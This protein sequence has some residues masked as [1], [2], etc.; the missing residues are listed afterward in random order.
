MIQFSFNEPLFHYTITIIIGSVT[1]LQTQHVLDLELTSELQKAMFIDKEK[2]A[3]IY[4]EGCFYKNVVIYVGCD[5]ISLLNRSIFSGVF[6]ELNQEGV[7]YSE[8]NNKLYAAMIEFYTSNIIKG[9]DQEIEQD[10]TFSIS[11][12]DISITLRKE[13]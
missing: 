3:F 5:D 12:N 13:N 2:G 9:V 10:H 1:E 8:T 6:L 11:A 4:N 7:C